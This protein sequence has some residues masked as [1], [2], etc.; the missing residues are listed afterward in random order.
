MKVGF[1]KLGGTLTGIIALTMVATMFLPAPASSQDT[2]QSLVNRLDRMER[3]LR[4]LNRQ[5]YTGTTPRPSAGATALTP[6][7]PAAAPVG[8][9]E[10][11]AG[12]AYAARMAS[13]MSQMETDLRTV[14]GTLETITHNLDQVT[15][16]LDKLVADIDARLSTLE[17]GGQFGGQPGTSTTALGAAPRI[18]TGPGISAAP[19]TVGV[20]SVGPATGGPVFGTAPRTL[21]TISGSDL[22]GTETPSGA[23][24]TSPPA[25]TARLAPTSPQP[26]DTQTGLPK[27]TPIQQYDFAYKLLVQAEYDRAAAAFK[28]FTEAHPK[29]PLVSNAQFW[30]GRTYFV[31]KDYATA[32]KIFVENYQTLPKGAKAPDSLAGLGMALVRLD[33]RKVACTTFDKFMAEF[34]NASQSLKA[35]V[36]RERKQAE[37]GT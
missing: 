27:G 15:G 33:K 14:T 7:T 22:K 29:N 37:C 11:L 36:T 4:T 2:T 6:T 28:E 1:P 20:Q 21:G 31:R 17:R 8:G 24:P 23:N 10:Q 16:R 35:R 3:E 12:T 34:P 5:V 26:S 18:P 13:R 19:S 30:L 25:Q 32:A 9:A